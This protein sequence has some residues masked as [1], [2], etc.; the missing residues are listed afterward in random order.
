MDQIPK[1]KVFISFHHGDQK[2]KNQFVKLMKDE[3]LDR[4]VKIGEINNLD[5][6]EI[7]QRIREDYIAEVTVTVVLIGPCTW[8]RMHVDWE[9]GASLRATKKNP[10][11][12]LLGI[13]LPKHLDFRRTMYDPHLIPPRL[14]DNCKERTPYAC[15]YDWTDQREDIREWIHQAFQRRKMTP[16]PDN[17]RHPFEKI[18]SG[19][20]KGG[21]QGKVRS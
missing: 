9:I 19:K 3:M 6:E 16:Y 17:R 11:C 12:G 5:V 4:S 7:F 1:H 14:A 18:W 15:V 13:M 2:Y 10:R 20:C 8:K 21:W